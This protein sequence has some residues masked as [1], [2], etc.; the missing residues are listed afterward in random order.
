MMHP[1]TS[2]QVHLQ[3]FGIKLPD[4]IDRHYVRS[5]YVREPGVPEIATRGPGHT[6]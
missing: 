3:D 1:D 2:G 4:Q 5:L 6:L